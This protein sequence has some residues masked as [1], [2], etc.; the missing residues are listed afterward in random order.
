M[1]GSVNDGGARGDA[2]P[3]GLEEQVTSDTTL[4]STPGTTA[5]AQPAGDTLRLLSPFDE[6]LVAY[7]DRSAYDRVPGIP[8]EA[9]TFFQPCLLLNGR[10]VGSWQKTLTPKSGTVHLQFGRD[11]PRVEPASIDAQLARLSHFHG[12][13]ILR[14]A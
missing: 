10:L 14:T 1:V 2:S 4:W 7:K 13:P 6:L 11:L 9:I 5:D 8:D 3:G 12:V